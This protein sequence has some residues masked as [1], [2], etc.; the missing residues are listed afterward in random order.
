MP[1]LFNVAGPV[2]PT[3]DQT[4]ATAEDF[5]AGVGKGL[6]AAAA[7]VKR[8]EKEEE[9]KERR[10]NADTVNQANLDTQGEWG[11]FD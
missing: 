4:K 2:R 5:G 7:E 1:Q 9:L 3:F 6:Q 11:W 10:A 8:F